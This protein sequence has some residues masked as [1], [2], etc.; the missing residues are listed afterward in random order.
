MESKIAVAIKMKY[1]PVAVLWTNEKPTGAIE[2]SQGRWGCVAALLN[3]AA[4]GKT[5]VFSRQTFG[6]WGG[7]AGLGFGDTYQNFPGGIEYFLSTGNKEF[8]QS[9]AGQ[10]IAKNMPY[11]ENGEGFQK[12]PEIAKAYIANLPLTDIPFEYVVYKPLAKLE[13]GEVP[14]VVV[15]LVNPDQLSALTVLANYDR[16]TPD[17]VIVRFG[18]G[19]QQTGIMAYQ[20]CLSEN[21]RAVIGMTDISVRK[22]VEKDI[23]SFTMPY[24]MFL[25]LE[26]NVE[27]S[28]LQ[29]HEWQKILER[30]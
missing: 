16:T 18:A 4:K 28:F 8:C 22:I 21:P 9:E 17:N 15:L 26:A 11:L 5:A 14:K 24:Q 3:N 30:I 25:E 20:E 19:C 7:G 6:C 2:F 29:K 13:P 1:S 12:T 10:A 23:L 27:G